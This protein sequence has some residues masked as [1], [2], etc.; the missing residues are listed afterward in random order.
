MDRDNDQHI[1]VLCKGLKGEYQTDTIRSV[2]VVHLK[3][4]FV[5]LA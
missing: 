4:L 1:K 2:L 5:Y 3:F